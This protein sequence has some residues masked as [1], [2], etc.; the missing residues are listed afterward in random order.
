[1]RFWLLIFRSQKSYLN[2][3][4]FYLTKE[5]ARTFNDPEPLNR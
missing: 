5:I 4:I 3:G 2:I 1:M